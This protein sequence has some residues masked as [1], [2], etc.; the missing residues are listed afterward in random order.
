MEQLAHGCLIGFNVDDV[1]HHLRVRYEV[2]AAVVATQMRLAH[3]DP[4]HGA[5][6][7]GYGHLIARLERIAQRFQVGSHVEI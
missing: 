7:P 4:F 2:P 1:R 3:G 5:G 6:G